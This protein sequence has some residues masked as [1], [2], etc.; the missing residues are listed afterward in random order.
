MTRADRIVDMLKRD[1]YDGIFILSKENVRYLSGYTG[2]DSY[3]LLTADGEKYFITDGRYTEQAENECADYT[4][5]NWRDGSNTIASTVARIAGDNNMGVLVFESTKINYDL[6]KS[7]VESCD[8]R[9]KLEPIRTYVEL[10]RYIKSDDEISSTKRACEISEKALDMLYGYIKPGITEQE[11]ACELEYYM[12]KLGADDIGFETILLS[13]S[14]TS[15]LHGIPSSRK[16]ENG[17]F[18]LIDFGAK[19]NGYICDMTRTVVIGKAGEEQKKV[20]NIV[21]EAQ[22]RALETMRAGVKGSVPYNAIENVVKDTDYMDYAYQGVG[23]GVGLFLHEE[24][25]MGPKSEYI[26]EKNSIVTIEPGIYIPG[27]GGVRIEDM[28]LIQDDIGKILT[29]TTKELIEL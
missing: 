2:A 21:R 13:G 16:I 7:I 17:D 3:L 26:L 5:V 18:V 11:A 10:L 19:Y 12:K 22:A 14:R 15:L 6:Y 23:H 20:Y 1:S 28:V 29:H 4:I 8:D 27:W 9:T 24:P 25:F